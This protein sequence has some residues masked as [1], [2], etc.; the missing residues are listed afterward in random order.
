MKN[1]NFFYNRLFCC[2]HSCY[3]VGM[4]SVTSA[5]HYVKSESHYQSRSSMYIRGLI[6]LNWPKQF[7]LDSFSVETDNIIRHLPPSQSSSSVLS[8]QSSTPSHHLLLGT[9]RPLSHCQY[10]RRH[11]HEIS[12]LRSGQSTRSL[13]RKLAGRH[14]PESH[15]KPLQSEIADKNSFN[16]CMLGNFSCFWCFLLTFFK[17]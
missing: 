17:N 11:G 15:L 8:K 9:E 14:K 5:S 16:S 1:I 4:V 6:P 10:P 2:N 13:H 12:S 3:C 7:R